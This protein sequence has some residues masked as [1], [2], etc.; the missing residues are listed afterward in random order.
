MNLTFETNITGR[1][2]YTFYVPGKDRHKV[3]AMSTDEVTEY[4]NDNP[5]QWELI[6]TTVDTT[7]SGALKLEE[8]LRGY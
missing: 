2:K 8:V 6:S 4:I 5:Q 7:D 1:D 3:R